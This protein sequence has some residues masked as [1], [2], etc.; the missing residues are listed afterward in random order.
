MFQWRN[1]KVIYWILKMNSF[2]FSIWRVKKEDMNRKSSFLIETV[3][4][5]PLD[6]QSKSIFGHPNMSNITITMETGQHHAVKTLICSNCLVSEYDI[7][8][9]S[10]SWILH[11]RAIMQ[12]D[13][14]LQNLF[15]LFSVP[16]KYNFKFVLTVKKN[17]LV[18]F[19]MLP[20]MI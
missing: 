3:N 14:I 1:T 7:I 10:A 19:H 6:M 12:H 16:F 4:S 20:L 8:S 2:N 15:V 11:F 9:G 17:R 18:Y 13:F 5:E